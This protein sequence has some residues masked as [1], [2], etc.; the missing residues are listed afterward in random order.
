MGW[1]RPGSRLPQRG[2][3]S[4]QRSVTPR[5]CSVLRAVTLL[6]WHA[7]VKHVPAEQLLPLGL[8][9]LSTDASHAAFY[10]D[11]LLGAAIARAQWEKGTHTDLGCAPS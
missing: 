1:H 2:T 7:A 8:G 11:K 3:H 10:G 5:C 4:A 9:G 6:T